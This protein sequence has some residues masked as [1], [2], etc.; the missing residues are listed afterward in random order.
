MV[1]GIGNNSGISLA[2]MTP[3]DKEK[4]RNAVKELDSSMT[5]VAGER[6][7]QKEIVNKVFDDLKF[8]KHMLK[9]LAKTYF[10]SDF[11]RLTTEND[12]FE[13]LYEDLMK[14]GS[15]NP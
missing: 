14:K 1:A 9:K 7:L 10:N 3:T 4:I 6:D 15:S 12:E 5:R 11:E 13:S 2:G 8:P